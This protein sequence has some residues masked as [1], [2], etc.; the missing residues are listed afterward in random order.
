[1]ADDSPF[2]TAAADSQAEAEAAAGGAD[3]AEGDSAGEAAP[4]PEPVPTSEWQA[5]KE[6][7]LHR[8]N[9]ER[10]EAGCVSSVVLSMC[11]L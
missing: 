3:G 5:L 6:D 4:A 9:S 1:M 10:A 11:G 2:D 8:I 7:L